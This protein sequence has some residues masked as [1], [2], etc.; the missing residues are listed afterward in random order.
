MSCSPSDQR[1]LRI[2]PCPGT[3]NLNVFVKLF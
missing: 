3:G 1:R 2:E